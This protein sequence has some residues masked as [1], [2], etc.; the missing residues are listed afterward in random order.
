MHR[1]QLSLKTQRGISLT[2]LIVVFG[3]IIM[4]AILAL[5]VIPRLLEYKSAKDAIVSVKATKGTPKEMRTAFEK[6]AEINTISSITSHDLII[7]KV[8]NESEVAFD[9]ESRIPLFSNVTLLIHFAATTDA[10]GVIPE[11]PEVAPR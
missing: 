1:S 5:K 3:V 10:S 9:Y 8:N 2:G 4:I 7:T 6:Y 11:K